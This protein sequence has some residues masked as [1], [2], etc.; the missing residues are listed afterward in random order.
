MECLVEKGLAVDRDDDEGRISIP[1][2]LVTSRVDHHVTIPSLES[3]LASDTER[4]LLVTSSYNYAGNMIRERT[5][6]GYNNCFGS[7]NVRYIF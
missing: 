4:P 7:Q 6:G 3:N 2:C 1:L 5:K